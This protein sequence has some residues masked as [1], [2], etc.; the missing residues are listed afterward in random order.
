MNV[1]ILRGLPGSGKS[2]VRQLLSD[3]T[4]FGAVVV[5]ADDFFTDKNGVYKFDGAKLMAAHAS[6]HVRFVQAL[7][8]NTRWVIVDNC[9]VKMADYQFY[10]DTAKQYHYKVTVLAVQSGATDAELAK[11]NKHGC[12]EETIRR[13]RERWEA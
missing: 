6:C 5:S 13:M 9:N 10:L 8:A 7:E 3:G 4:N 2:T 12:P 1:I 11:R